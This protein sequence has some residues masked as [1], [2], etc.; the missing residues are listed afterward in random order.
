MHMSAVSPGTWPGWPAQG[1]GLVFKARRTN[2][3]LRA[4]R[5]PPQCLC[6]GCWLIA[7]TAQWNLLRKEVWSFRVTVFWGTDHTGP[8]GQP[9]QAC[10]Y[11]RTSSKQKASGPSPILEGPLEN[12]RKELYLLGTCLRRFVITGREYKGV[13]VNLEQL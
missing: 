4:C 13:D 2:L 5:Q 10:P 8:L 3:G 7:E 12:Y 6:C 1:N 9:A 11:S